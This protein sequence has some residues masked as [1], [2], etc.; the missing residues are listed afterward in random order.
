[1]SRSVIRRH[2]KVLL[3]DLPVWVDFKRFLHA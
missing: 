1:M 3:V 2:Q